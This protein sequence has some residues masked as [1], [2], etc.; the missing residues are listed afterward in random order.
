MKNKLLDAAIILNA[1]GLKVIPTNDPTRP[2]GKKPLV[3]WKQYQ[4]G[5][6]NKQVKNIFNS[7]NLGGLAVLTGAGMETIDI[8]LKYAKT[9][10]FLSRLLDAII[11]G[12]GAECYESLIL[13]KTIS[14][15]Y[16]LSYLTDVNE[17][18]KKLASRYT[19]KDEQ[20]NEHD[21]TRVLIET[22]GDGG[23]ILAP[24]AIGYTYDNQ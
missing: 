14:G 21:K 7:Q 2:D 22:R 16:H 19:T 11:L 6:T 23:Y 12:V 17:G 18:N 4:A 1:A 10:E 13:T 8:D 9:G 24:P 20:K 5:Q 3:S 15:G